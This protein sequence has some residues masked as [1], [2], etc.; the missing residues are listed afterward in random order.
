MM[1]ATLDWLASLPTP[2]TYGVLMVMSALENVFP[3][4]PADVAVALGAFLSARGAV[5][6]ML[7]GVVCWAANCASA[8]GMYALG[9]VYGPALFREGWGR[10]LLPPEAMTAVAYAYHRHGVWGI[11]LTRFLPGVRAAVMP[12]AGV[13]A[14]PPERALPPAFLASALW[15]AGLIVVGSALGLRWEAIKSLIVGANRALS[16]VALIAAALFSLWLARRMR[17]AGQ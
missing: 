4:V 13:V 5:T 3:P 8:F 17:R 7:L 10:S 9:R 1:D 14:L 16:V 2:A 11:F 12:F 15:Y 6:P